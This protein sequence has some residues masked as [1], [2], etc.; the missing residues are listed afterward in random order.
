MLVIDFIKGPLFLEIEQMTI[1]YQDGYANHAFLGFI[2]LS[3]SIE[4]LGACLDNYA[5]DKLDRSGNRFRLAIK[6]LFPNEY[7]KY[8]NNDNFDIYKNLRCSLAHSA[9]PGNHIGLSEKKHEEKINIKAHLTTN[10]NGD[11]TLIFE[12][13]LNDFKGAC[14]KLISKIDNKEINNQKAYGHLFYTPQD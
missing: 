4:F 9:R 7:E 13:F 10:N 12:D 11:L 3:S 1:N 2:L 5:W 6:E 8:S 14:K